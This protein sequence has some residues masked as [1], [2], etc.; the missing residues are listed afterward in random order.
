MNF[1]L[2]VT[3][4]VTLLLVGISLKA[5]TYCVT[6]FAGL[7]ATIENAQDFDIINVSGTIHATEEILIEKTLS[8]VGS[9][10]SEIVSDGSSRIFTIN[11]PSGY[12]IIACLTLSGAVADG[13]G[14]AV[15]AVA[16]VVRFSGC[17]LS[18]NRSADGGGAV[19]GEGDVD[20]QF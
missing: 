4:S 2:K 19:Y 18:N 7:K 17:T 6:D 13:N 20:I 1:R 11:V 15:A 14:G 16:G 12:V 5:E 8:I 9:S 10:G 3:L